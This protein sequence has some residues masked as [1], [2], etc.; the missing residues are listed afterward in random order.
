MNLRTAAVCAAGLASSCAFEPR[1]ERRAES[2]SLDELTRHLRAIAA[3]YR[4]WMPLEPSPLGASNQG[5]GAGGGSPP[6]YGS[7]AGDSAHAGQLLYVFARDAAAYRGLE[8]GAPQRDQVLVLEAHALEPLVMPGPGRPPA[9]A[10]QTPRGW[11]RAGALT[12]IHVMERIDDAW[13]YASLTPEGEVTQLGRPAACLECHA[14]APFDE[15]FGATLRG[16]RKN[17]KP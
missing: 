10:L 16:V 12:G 15:L 14:H 1:V 11:V 7:A 13:R 17:A 5:P 4:T 3:D 2:S 6:L 9:D 8:S